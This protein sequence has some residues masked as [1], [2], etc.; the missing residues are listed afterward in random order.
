MSL[1]QVSKRSPC[2]HKWPKRR[3]LLLCCPFLANVDRTL[4]IFRKSLNSYF[5]ISKNKL[6]HPRLGLHPATKPI[7]SRCRSPRCLHCWYWYIN[8]DAVTTTTNAASLLCLCLFC[9]CP[10]QLPPS[11]FSA[12]L[13]VPLHAHLLHLHLSAPPFCFLFAL[14]STFRLSACLSPPSA[15]SFGLP[16]LSSVWWP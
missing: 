7:L 8:A 10:N 5:L 6:R 4:S 13:P 11:P 12:P 3:C 1:A 15:S 9:I 14:V 16:S 2:V